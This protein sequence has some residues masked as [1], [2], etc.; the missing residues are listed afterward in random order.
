MISYRR[1]E[2]VLIRFPSSDLITYKKRPALVVQADGLNTGLHQ[3]I[4]AMISSNLKRTGETRV[5]ITR[6][7]AEG[8]Q[9]GLLTDS[10][11]VADNLATVLDREVDKAIGACPDMTAVDH[12]LRKTLGL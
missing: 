1:G 5:L 11:V 8:R 2:V 10:V 3:R 4:V 12:A 7:S 6:A 9:M